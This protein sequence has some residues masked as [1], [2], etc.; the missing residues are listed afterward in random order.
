MK[1]CLLKEEKRV[2]DLLIREGFNIVIAE[3]NNEYEKR[4][5]GYKKTPEFIQSPFIGGGSPDDFFIDVI[6]PNGSYL[7]KNASNV[8][9]IIDQSWEKKENLRI[10]NQDIL[11]EEREILINAIN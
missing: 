6:S 9:G 11:Q 1:Q 7:N 3:G 2:F 4:L 10:V 5:G 8:G